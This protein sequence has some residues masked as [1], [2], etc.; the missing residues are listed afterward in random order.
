MYQSAAR[1]TRIHG[2][3]STA[4][5]PRC[6]RANAAHRTTCLY[7]GAVMPAPV[8]P[9]PPKV[10]PANIDALVRDA[11]RGGDVGKLRAA[12]KAQG[13]EATPRPVVTPPVVTPP[14]VTRPAVTPPVAP[15]RAPAPALSPP[16]APRP[17][18]PPAAT[19]PAPPSGRSRSEVLDALVLAAERT[20]VAL[21]LGAALDALA[22]VVA[23]AR[24]FAEPTPGAAHTAAAHTAAAPTATLTAGPTPDAA[25]AVPAPVEL[26]PFRFAWMLVVSGV[27][28]AHEVAA[29]LGLDLVTA[30]QLAYLAGPR[31]AARSDDAALLESRAGRAREAGLD[32]RVC[33]RAA[34]A[35][36]PP[37]ETLLTV[38]PDG[39]WLTCASP[40]WRDPPEPST[41]PAGTPAPTDGVFLLVSG[42]VE[43]RD[44]RGPRD[45]GRWARS[46]L[47]V[48]GPVAERRV[49]VVDVH[50]PDRI[51]RVVEGIVD[52]RG[53]PSHVDGSG[54]RTLAAWL[55]AAITRWPDARVEPRRTCAAGA[56]T[57]LSEDGRQSGSGWPLFE[58]YSRL[59]RLNAG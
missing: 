10:V 25:P 24:T 14:V 26:P 5:C 42:E 43:V 53:D 16:P 48:A 1:S 9:P 21:D 19:S 35:E 59:A 4:P 22:L 52:L 58:E 34:L 33:A 54:R 8:A 23:E 20:R 32:V 41:R 37:A 45:P 13:I 56:A 44:Q 28:A 51:V 7:C 40:V 39:R 15:P 57:K 11:M 36:L 38:E 31:V 30:R 50:L 12:L 6:A 49:L 3:V 2:R 47:T 17:A 55:D 29:G 27:P 46:R 18:P